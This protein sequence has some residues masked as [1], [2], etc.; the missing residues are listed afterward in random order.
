MN[1]N[2]DS[3]HNHF[4]KDPGSALTHLIAVITAIVAACP[5]IY[6]S[7]LSGSSTAVISM[8]IFIISMIMLYGASTI[9]HSFDISKEINLILRRIDHS[10][11]FILIAGSY[12]PVC[13][14][15]L[16]PERGI[17]LLIFMW[18]AA[19]LGIIIKI[20]FINCPHW[21]SS[22]IYISMG[23]TCVFVMR[24]LL[25]T[26]PSAAFLWLLMGGLIYTAGGVIYALKLKVFE[27]LPRYFGSHEIFHVFVMG[28]SFCHFIFMYLYLI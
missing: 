17:P 1:N 2:S 27:R 25:S 14:L 6:K 4:L 18:T 11:I 5:L 15:V 19:T 28:G 26:L 8:I 21:F 24:P 12:T 10:M 9:Y 20:F 16:T 13:L 23:W 3:R 7:V 22:L